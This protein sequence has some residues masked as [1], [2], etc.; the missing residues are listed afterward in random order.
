[1]NRFAQIFTSAARTKITL[2]VRS[3]KE[4]I[5]FRGGFKIIFRELPPI[6]WAMGDTVRW[7]V[8]IGETWAT[9]T[10]GTVAEAMEQIERKVMTTYARP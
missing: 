2:I 4:W 7:K 9:G 10:A 8:R 3:R 5:G 1:M 6:M